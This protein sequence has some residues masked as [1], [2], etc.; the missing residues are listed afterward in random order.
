M[1]ATAVHVFVT[2]DGALTLLHTI[3]GVQD[4][5]VSI[6]RTE[7]TVNAPMAKTA[8][9]LSEWQAQGSDGRRYVRNKQFPDVQSYTPIAV[10]ELSDAQR[11]SVLQATAQLVVAS[12]TDHPSTFF[13]R[14]MQTPAALAESHKMLFAMRFRASVVVFDAA[15]G[16]PVEM[17]VPSIPITFL[18]ANVRRGTE[19]GLKPLREYAFKI[20]QNELFYCE[21]DITNAEQ[22]I[23]LILFIGRMMRYPTLRSVNTVLLY[24]E[25]VPH[26]LVV[27]PRIPDIAP[28]TGASNFL[29][30]TI[31]ESEYGCFFRH[32]FA[33]PGDYDDGPEPPRVRSIVFEDV[34]A[35]LE[36]L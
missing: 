22:V 34:V 18:V 30:W 13:W 29:Q 17:R 11:L 33:E 26:S 16:P 4:A 15:I 23:S 5:K 9:L 35:E 10:I 31:Y 12:I 21:V 1:S 24:G 32:C 27:K 8:A 14:A 3:Q 20:N 6:N 25:R 36:P 28:R 2:G 19:A 7:R